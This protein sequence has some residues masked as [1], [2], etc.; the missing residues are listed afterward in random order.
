MKN[1]LMPKVVPGLGWSSMEARVPAPSSPPPAPASSPA[2]AASPRALASPPALG[3]SAR[4]KGTLFQYL[5]IS[6]WLTIL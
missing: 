2:T 6:R 5:V 1:V 4:L 3:S